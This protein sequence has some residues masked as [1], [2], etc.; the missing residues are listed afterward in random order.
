M[1]DCHASVLCHQNALWASRWP[2]EEAPQPHRPKG[3]EDFL[4]YE[5]I[6]VKMCHIIAFYSGNMCIYCQCQNKSSTRL[7]FALLT[8][9]VKSID[10]KLAETDRL[11]LVLYKYSTRVPPKA[12]WEED[13]ELFELPHHDLSSPPLWPI[14]YPVTCQ[15]CLSD[16]A[17]LSWLFSSS[18]GWICLNSCSK[19]AECWCSVCTKVSPSRFWSTP[20]I[21]LHSRLLWI[22]F[23]VTIPNNISL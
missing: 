16:S 4:I 22:F 18:R 11:S 17:L 8:T 3:P 2:G 6:C 12:V 19:R 5:T 20:L 9:F 21:Y 10:R 15:L 1:C 7:H 13:A 14:D 23:F